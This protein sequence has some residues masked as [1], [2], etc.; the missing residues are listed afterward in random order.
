MHSIE[1]VLL[2]NRIIVISLSI[3]SLS[4]RE[5]DKIDK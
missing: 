2:K 3:K 5:S 4:E 1:L